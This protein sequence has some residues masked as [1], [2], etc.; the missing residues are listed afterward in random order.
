VPSGGTNETVPGDLAHLDRR[1]QGWNE[2]VLMDPG[3]ERE[4]VT[5]GVRDK[6]DVQSITPERVAETYFPFLTITTE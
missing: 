3:G 4:R 6:R 1:T 2:G 5:S